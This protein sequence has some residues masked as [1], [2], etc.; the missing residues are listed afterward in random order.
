MKESENKENINEEPLIDKDTNQ[1]KIDDID[2]KKDEEKPVDQL[3]VGSKK[4][5]LKKILINFCKIN[6]YQKNI[7]KTMHQK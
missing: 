5:N 3:E 7:P 4:K 1:E 2:T 6:F